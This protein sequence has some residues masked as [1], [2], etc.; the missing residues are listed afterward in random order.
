MIGQKVYLLM[1][2]SNTPKISV[3]VPIFNAEK[4]LTR[5]VDSILQQDYP[6][7]EI[8]LINDGSTDESAKIIDDYDKNYTNIIVVHTKNRGQSAARN[9]GIEIASGELIAFVDSDDYIDSSMLRKLYA[10]MD[11]EGSEISSCALQYRQSNK[12]TKALLGL[13]ACYGQ[14]Q[15]LKYLLESRDNESVCTKLFAAR[16]LGKGHATFPEGLKHEESVFLTQCYLQV[17]NLS[18][19]DEALYNYVINK[20][21]TTQSLLKKDYDYDLVSTVEMVVDLLK[22]KDLNPELL[23]GYRAKKRASYIYTRIRKKGGAEHGTKVR[24]WFIDNFKDIITAS[25]I[26]PYIKMVSMSIAM[27]PWVYVPLLKFIALL[28]GAK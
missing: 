20:Q 25:R 21:S 19:I 22:D 10:S 24:A 4:W 26:S 28:K 1:Q 16:L 12:T 8:I 18:Y 15:A 27:G 14:S 2:K 17:E 23:L 13:E 6:Y 5:C 9:R 11:K 3:I 7:I